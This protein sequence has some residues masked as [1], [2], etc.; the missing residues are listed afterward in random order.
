MGYCMDNR[1]GVFFI[2]KENVPR[3][4]QAIKNLATQTHRGGGGSYG[5]GKKVVKHFSWVETNEI[6]NAKNIEEVFEA[7]SW[8]AEVDRKGNVTDIYFNSEKIGDE[9]ILFEAIAPYVKDGSYIEMSGE[10]SAIWR[11]AFKDKEMYEESAVLDWDDNA[12]IVE[13]ILK[14][15]KKELPTLMGIHPELDRKIEKILKGK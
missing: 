14:A 8:T 7:W 3:A 11:W 12:G 15:K 5:P 1:G 9:A 2:S 13:K 10:D 6:T 4:L